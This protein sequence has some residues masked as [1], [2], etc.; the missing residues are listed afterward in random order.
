MSASDKT[1][2]RAK[3]FWQRLTAWYG[4][5]ITEAYG[6]TIPSD[7][8][9]LIDAHTNDQVKAVLS[10]VRAKYLQ[11]PP[12][13]PEV[14]SLF[15]KASSKPISNIPTMQSMLSKFVVKHRKLTKDQVRWPWR[16]LYRGDAHSGSGFEV[17][18]VDVP[19]DGNSPGYRVMVE[20]MQLEQAA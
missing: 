7:W 10:L 3:R 14:D 17:V 13:L 4:T 19:A 2:D 15:V 1:S 18:G 12:S 6:P 8:A 20:D 9:A 16:Y 5:R 11:Y